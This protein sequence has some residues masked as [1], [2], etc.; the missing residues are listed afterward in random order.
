M[1][2]RN[3]TVRDLYRTC[4]DRGATE[5]DEAMAWVEAENIAA[6]WKVV[7][8]W[9]QYIESG[10]AAHRYP[11]PKWQTPKGRASLT[12]ERADQLIKEMDADFEIESYR[13]PSGGGPDFKR[14]P[15]HARMAFAQ[16]VYGVLKTEAE[17]EEEASR[18]LKAGERFPPDDADA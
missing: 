5:L 18:R 1:D 12:L 7:A 2:Y 9:F 6:V 3:T 14:L 13:F 15:A 8:R 4:R 16:E 11:D 10:E 17:I